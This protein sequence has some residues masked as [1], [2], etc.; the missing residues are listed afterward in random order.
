MADIDRDSLPTVAE[1]RKIQRERSRAAIGQV[2]GQHRRDRLRLAKQETFAVRRRQVMHPMLAPTFRF[3]GMLTTMPVTGL[4][5]AL[6]RRMGRIVSRPSHEGPRP[7]FAAAGG[8]MCEA[9]RIDFKAACEG[10]I[11][12]R[13]YFEKWG[14]APSP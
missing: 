6:L 4:P 3:G 13:Q 10:R 5:G 9:Q 2:R 14:D 11:T 7:F 8:G 12:W 1:A